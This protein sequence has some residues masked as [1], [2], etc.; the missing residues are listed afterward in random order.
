MQIL[1]I[2]N[3]KLALDGFRLKGVTDYS[4]KYM[5]NNY[6]ELNVKMI[7]KFS[8][9]EKSKGIN[10]MRKGNYKFYTDQD[11]DT[12]VQNCEQK[13]KSNTIGDILLGFALG[14]PVWT[15]LAWLIL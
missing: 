2:E 7:T 9:N 12:I 11:V 5:D 6:S 10:E 14:F 8:D 15:I 4:I 1:E 3:G 13:I